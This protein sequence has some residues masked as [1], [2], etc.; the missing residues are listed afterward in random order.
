MTWSETNSNASLGFIF[1]ELG[2]KAFPAVE[3]I[4][5]T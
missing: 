5:P 2:A 1:S 3:Q 4:H